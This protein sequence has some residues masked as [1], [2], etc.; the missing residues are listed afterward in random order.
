MPTGEPKFLVL[1]HVTPATRLMEKRRQM[2]EVQE[3]LEAQ[4]SEFAHKE[5]IFKRREEELK[6]RDMDLQESLIKFSNF[7]Q[8]NEK[9]RMQHDKKAREE[10]KAAAKLA[11]ESAALSE[12]IRR[13]EAQKEHVIKVLET[14]MMAYT[15]F[16]EHTLEVA[17]EFHEIK[18]ISDR[19]RILE[20]TNATLKAENE[21]KRV[22]HEQERT[23]YQSYL[24]A[25][26]N[27]IQSLRNKIANL[28]KEEEA[29]EQEVRDKELEKD[30]NLRNLSENMLK[31]GQVCMATSNLYS[32]CCKKSNISHPPDESNP[33]NQLNVVGHFVGDLGE[34]IK[35]WRQR[36]SAKTEVRGDKEPRPAVPRP[37]TAKAPEGGGE[38]MGVPRGA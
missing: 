26:T 15:H 3:T 5:D 34:I 20:S 1:E 21:S 9:K 33:I 36:Q 22:A 27:E 30:T 38:V 11:E 19:Y 37:G 7:L 8:E 17:D 6:R 24:K 18:E 32:R 16:L 4:K 35:E 2:F 14:Q 12:E 31:H 10:G 28:K 23:R 29:V 25:K 13:L